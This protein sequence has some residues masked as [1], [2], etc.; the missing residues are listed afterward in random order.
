MNKELLAVLK[1]KDKIIEAVKNNQ[2]VIIEAPTGS[3]KTTQ[4][5][6]ILFNAGVNGWGI[7]GVTQ[8]RRIAS[9]SVS[10]RIAEEMDVE[11]GRLVGYKIRFEDKTSAHTKIK[12]MTDGILLEELR[13]DPDLLK[14]SIIIVDEAHERSLNID[15]ILGLLKGILKRRKDFKVVVSSATINASIFSKYFYNAPIISVE[16]KPY[17]IEI[18]YSPLTKKE[19]YEEILTSIIDIVVSIERKKLAGDILIFLPGEDSIKDCCRRLESLNSYDTLKILPLY[20]RLSIEE[21]NNVFREY[22]G[23]RKVIVATNIAETSIT[24]DGIVFVIDPG[25][26][27]INY[28]N[29]RTFTSFLE[30]KAISKASCDQRKGRAGRT[31]PGVV[32]R[33]YS[34]EDYLNRE[35]YTKEEIYRT[36]LSEV[37]LRMADLGLY[38]YF[39]FDFISPPNKGAIKSAIETLIAIGALD[40]NYYITPLGKRMVDF[41]LIPRL[42]RILIEA[43]DNYPHVINCIL[44]IISFLSTRSPFLYPAG[45]EIESRNAQR[46]LMVKGGDFFSWINIFFKYIKAKNKENFCKEY[47]LDTKTMNEIVNIHFQLTNMVIEK[48]YQIGG[49]LEYDDINIC[50]CSGLKQYICIKNK[51]KRTNEYYSATEKAIRIHPGS[52]L[53]GENP[54]WIVGGEIVNTGRTYIRTAAMI[55]EKIIKEKFIDIYNVLTNKKLTKTY[56]KEESTKIK[57]KI[58]YENKK[59]KLLDKYFEIKENKRQKYVFV[60][61]HIIIQLKSRKERLL[62]YNFGDLKAHLYFKDILI[63]KD[64]FNSLLEYFDKIDLNNGINTKYPKNKFLFYPDNWVQIFKYAKILLRPSLENPRSKKSGFLTLSYLEENNCYKFCLEE[65]FFSAI[66]TSYKALQV[67]FSSSLKVWNED[68]KKQ[69]EKIHH[70][71]NTYLEE[72]EV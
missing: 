69:L 66:E 22:V 32:Y 4:I 2:V 25:Y 20:A 36:D 37:V 45:E 71:L 48:G 47:Y 33:L 13:S 40:D 34:E 30:I 72:L 62:H 46:K 67:L 63:L 28:Y 16:T 53:F 49:R 9:V 26:S 35:E 57:G 41:P 70:K 52:F 15:F 59:V 12:I 8:P 31:A 38:N 42:S 17:P 43:I 58:E 50:I 11:L 39:D 10:A 23:K 65:D 27:K 19:D 44:I 68:E 6:Q 51:K 24:I 18:I 61:Y 55:S 60:P 14:Y 54:E 21:Q 56:L 29:P 3:G 1:F 7:I 64:S 5:P